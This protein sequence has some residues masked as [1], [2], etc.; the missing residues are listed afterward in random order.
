[1]NMHAVGS[2]PRNEFSIQVPG[3]E[4]FLVGREGY[5]LLAPS[6]PETGS[7]FGRNSFTAFHLHEAN[8][9]ASEGTRRW[10]L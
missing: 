1:M 7:I 10:P 4:L 9:E 3:K 5:L 8:T 2:L 6:L